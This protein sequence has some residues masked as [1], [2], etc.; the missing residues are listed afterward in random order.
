M[1]LV[2]TAA[3]AA[4]PDPLADELALGRPELLD[5][6]WPHF[7][8][9]TGRQLS[10]EELQ[11]EVV[12]D[13]GVYAGQAHRSETRPTI[14][15]VPTDR[16][17]AVLL[18]EAAHLWVDWGPRALEEG[19]A[20]TL[21][22]CVYRRMHGEPEFQLYPRV[23]MTLPDLLAWT[24]D[25]GLDHQAISDRYVASYWLARVLEPL[26]TP[27]QRWSRQGLGW[28]ELW[29]VIGLEGSFE[30][31]DGEPRFYLETGDLYMLA[32]VS[33]LGPS[34]S[35]DFDGDGLDHAA[36]FALETNP[37]SWDSDGDGWWDGAQPPEGARPWPT[38]QAC[39]GLPTED[40]ELRLTMAGPDYARPATR[41]VQAR[42]G[43]AEFL[44]AAPRRRGW[45]TV[46]GPALAPCSDTL[47][48]VQGAWP[49]R[50]LDP[51]GDGLLDPQERELGTDPARYD[52]DGD[53]WWD[54]AQP[55][56]DA[57]RYEGSGWRCLGTQR[58]GSREARIGGPDAEQVEA[59]L[60]RS[61][62]RRT[63]VVGLRVKGPAQARAWIEVP[64]LD[65][66]CP[67]LTFT[68]QVDG[69]LVTP[70]R[71]EPFRVD[72]CP[73]TPAPRP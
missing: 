63:K 39:V 12:E 7:E 2:W 43:Q 67:E 14:E 47:P 31:K 42:A 27:E 15:L 35:S 53:G 54:G 33:S 65:K 69:C 22:E 29:E 9:C 49:T 1:H 45:L 25:E 56:E 16:D 48:P 52:T 3:L 10:F 23:E 20:D 57:I 64:E 41:A 6:A 13:L 36:E 11:V 24:T 55:P 30:V 4:S 73:A 40:G 61:V 26:L 58:W 18:H 5:L 8:A 70:R 44:G 17:E 59:W 71:G 19:M 32:L 66:P 72:D 60:T 50:L 34:R 46:E 38:E 51:D 68:P 28:P 37:F 21:A 62:V